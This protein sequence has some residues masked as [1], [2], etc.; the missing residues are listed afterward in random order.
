M[1]AAWRDALPT[2]EFR[3]AQ[4]APEIFWKEEGLFA[5]AL[6]LAFGFITFDL[7]FGLST[8]GRLAPTAWTIATAFIDG[9][10]IQLQKF[11]HN[12][13]RDGCRLGKLHFH[14]QAKVDLPTGLGA[15]RAR[16]DQRHS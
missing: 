12:P 6:D 16:R 2:F 9:A 11:K 4:S 7:G 15:N 3:C 13:P 14:P 5:F 8:F 1:L 10:A